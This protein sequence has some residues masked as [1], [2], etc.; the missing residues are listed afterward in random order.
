MFVCFV[1]LS[2]G[3]S[4]ALAV[5]GLAVDQAGLKLRNICL[6]LLPEC[7]CQYDAFFPL[8]F[9]WKRDAIADGCEP[10]CGYWELNSGPLEEQSVLLTAE[11]S[12]QPT[13]ALL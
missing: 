12:I 7:M 6:P 9:L 1:F 10:L 2:Q 3:F 8:L 13:S 4:V 5:L 11:P